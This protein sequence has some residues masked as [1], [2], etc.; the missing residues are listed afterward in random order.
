MSREKP[1]LDFFDTQNAS[2]FIYRSNWWANII[3]AKD[4]IINIFNT[5]SITKIMD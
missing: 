3:N 4:F 2:R 5:K 1:I